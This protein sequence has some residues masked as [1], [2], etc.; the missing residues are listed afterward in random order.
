MA[1]FDESDVKKFTSQLNAKKSKT[2]DMQLQS[3]DIPKVRKGK[4]EKV[5]E[6]SAPN[7]KKGTHGLPV[8]LTS[9]CFGIKFKDIHVYHVSFKPKVKTESEQRSLITQAFAQ[10]T[11][12]LLNG[13]LILTPAKLAN[14][15]VVDK[16][17]EKGESVTISFSLTN[18]RKV[19]LQQV[20]DE[21]LKK[22]LDGLEYTRILGDSV[23]ES[24]Q[25][26]V[27]NSY[28]M[29]LQS[30]LIYL[31]H[32]LLSCLIFISSTFYAIATITN[33]GRDSSQ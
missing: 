7:A 32:F 8:Q 31:N 4:R 19:N 25:Q 29:N 24:S 21:I 2:K 16:L 3:L 30:N 13:T 11:D 17:E 26:V 18:Q 23:Y 5:A 10:R 33:C 20:F 15:I 27:N 6:A 28:D 14:T 1:E 12:W 9:N 22:A